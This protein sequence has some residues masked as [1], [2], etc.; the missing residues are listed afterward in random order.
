MSATTTDLSTLPR[1]VWIQKEGRSK[2]RLFIES[3]TKIIEDLKQLVFG[4]SRDEY[5]AFYL[6]QK[7]QEQYLIPTDVS[8][9]EPIQFQRI[10][11]HHCTFFLLH[12]QINHLF[13]F[14]VCF[15][16]QLFNQ[17]MILVWVFGWKQMMKEEPV[18]C[19]AT[20]RRLAMSIN[21][22][23]NGSQIVRKK[24]LQFVFL[25]ITFFERINLFSFS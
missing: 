15:Y 20:S 2:M 4:D 1:E 19:A 11:G 16:F 14:I 21:V 3:D 7:I 25:E 10:N 12:Q 17:M 23:T 6:Q 8:P 24:E 9:E 22:W 5:Y 13:S 18:P